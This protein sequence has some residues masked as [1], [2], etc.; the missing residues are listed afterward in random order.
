MGQLFFHVCNLHIYV[1][2]V[3]VGLFYRS[4]TVFIQELLKYKRTMVT[5]HY[6][7]DNVRQDKTASLNR[8]EQMSA[9]TL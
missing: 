8:F 1:L 2:I 7:S 3:A 6:I 4:G 9:V 5:F